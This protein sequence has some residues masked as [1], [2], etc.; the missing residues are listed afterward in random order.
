MNNHNTLS[1]TTSEKENILSTAH[2][3]S[4]LENRPQRTLI[5]YI[6]S[7][8]LGATIIGSALGINSLRGETD[9][10]HEQTGPS[11]EEIAS[12]II[13]RGP[14]ENDPLTTTEIRQD[15]AISRAVERAN[16]DLRTAHDLTYAD[17]G[18]AR[19]TLE[20]A[21]EIET[22]ITQNKHRNVLP[23]DKI[24][25]WYDTE[26]GYFVGNTTDEVAE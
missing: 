16:E 25:V 3:E 5:R 11:P 14:S 13:E 12:Q 23:G 4:K 17:Q 21:R 22:S 2:E 19:V 18:Q 8:I 26:T 9:T 6:G 24:T 1:P 15:E 7:G 10:S 20:T